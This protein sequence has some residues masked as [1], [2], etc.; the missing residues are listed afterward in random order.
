MRIRD[1]GASARR[2]LGTRL[3]YHRPV[4]HVNDGCYG[5][6]AK[7][8]SVGL[9]SDGPRFLCV[10]A[11]AQ[12]ALQG[13]E[14]DRFV[15]TCTTTKACFSCVRMRPG[16][17]CDSGAAQVFLKA[18]FETDGY[19]FFSSLSRSPAS[20]EKGFTASS[21]SGAAPSG[22]ARTRPRSTPSARG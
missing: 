20:A 12:G 1:A 10:R 4:R 2:N 19:S 6:S 7:F 9:P 18:F 14:F 16:T 11:E 8:Y 15:T 13:L 5:A 22:P 21:S 17:Y 3:D